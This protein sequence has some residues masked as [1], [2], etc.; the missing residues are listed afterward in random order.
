MKNIFTLIFVFGAF[1]AISQNQMTI[2]FTNGNTETF[3]LNDIDSI[4]YTSGNTVSYNLGDEGPAG[5]IIVYDKGSYSNGWRY[6]ELSPNNL[7]QGYGTG[8]CYVSSQFLSGIGNGANNTD[9]MVNNCADPNDAAVLCKNYM[10]VNNGVTFDDWYLPNL[11][12]MLYIYNLK[13]SLGYF[14]TQHWN[15][16]DGQYDLYWTSTPYDDNEDYIVRFDGW[17]TTRLESESNRVRAI[18]YF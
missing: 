4:T 17:N 3:L 10:L 6:M 8:H 15:I 7:S 13:E 12:E 16:N 9:V 18:R 5:G 2:H 1:V 11:E 14:N